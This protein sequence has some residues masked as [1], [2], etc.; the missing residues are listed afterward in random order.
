MSE[1]TNTSITKIIVR[2]GTNDD[3]TKTTLDV[4]EPGWST[5]T[6]Q[7]FIGDGSSK[8]GI[9]IGPNGD[10]TGSIW[11][12]GES[13]KINYSAGNV[14]INT[15]DPS[16]DLTVVG[17]IQA[18]NNIY[19]TTGNFMSAGVDIHT[20]FGGTAQAGIW[21]QHSNTAVYDKQTNNVA[22]RIDNGALMI[23]GHSGDNQGGRIQLVSKNG[24]AK[25]IIHIDNFTS[26]FRI[27]QNKKSWMNI[28]KGKTT[29][30]PNISADSFLNT[31][32]QAI[33]TVGGHNDVL[34]SAQYNAVN[35][36]QL[37]HN[38][39]GHKDT[40]RFMGRRAAAG[41]DWRTSYHQIVR[42]V[43]ITPMG[44]I[45]FGGNELGSTNN[46]LLEFGKS[47]TTY[48]EI[49]AD[50]TTILTPDATKPALKI[51]TGAGEGKVLTSDA[52]GNAT[53]GAGGAGGSGTTVYKL[54]EF[55]KGEGNSMG[56]NQALYVLDSDKNIRCIGVDS[57]SRNGGIHSHG[58]HMSY[59][60]LPSTAG[61]HDKPYGDITQ[62]VS[63]CHNL[64]V[65]TSSGTVFASGFNYRGKLGL[66]GG[67]T[68]EH[69]TLSR[70]SVTN[71]RKIIV[72]GGGI[73]WDH[74]A[75]PGW[76]TTYYLKTND[77]LWA[78]GQDNEGMFF[79]IGY[80]G[81]M[82]NGH[83]VFGPTKV[84]DNVKDALMFGSC[85]PGI[86]ENRWHG[87]GFALKNDGTVWTVGTP[88][89]GQLGHGNTNT[90]EGY[91]NYWKQ[92]GA[93]GTTNLLAGKNVVKIKGTGYYGNTTLYALTD[94]GKLYGWGRGD[95][96]QL[97]Q[98]NY[99]QS[100][101]EPVLVYS[102]VEDFWISGGVYGSL[103][104]KGTNKKMYACGYNGRGQLGTGEI[105]TKR[106][107][108][109]T[110]PSLTN[111]T[112]E[113]GMIYT[114]SLGSYGHAVALSDPAGPYPG[115]AWAC[116]Y[117]GDGQ[118]GFGGKASAGRAKWSRI[119]FNKKII[120]VRVWY[121]YGEGGGNTVVVSEDG[122]LYATGYG[123]YDIFSWNSSN[124]R[125][126]SKISL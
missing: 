119:P 97:A 20:L 69:N 84:L 13:N 9:L 109:T 71:V 4:G 113:I 122:E 61:G 100:N 26:Y 52:S 31:A 99:N 11:A 45:R 41:T 82:V 33:L 102:N 2:H 23:T 24:A 40:L 17:D 111:L 77:E 90:G 59:V 8:G 94:D 34:K 108:L 80:T 83:K 53:W 104:I 22:V 96:G 101:W 78:V 70:V 29:L 95:Y 18:S 58:P 81:N 55:Q 126:L 48:M 75:G 88:G 32:E 79:G 49:Q 25:N 107:S 1:S 66:V 118:C 120:D 36:L 57:Y 51:P 65:L 16:K 121:G 115:R 37:H 93:H 30:S 76:D 73:G 112:E 87:N 91:R 43:D 38:A 5:D 60:R 68:K 98:G 62:V 44:F 35:S 27:N 89:Y 124:R 14:G 15:V 125:Y 116:G 117:D 3:R 39:G 86:R 92:V 50:G 67:T 56:Q 123:I 46:E 54:E 105:Y 10:S 85:S 47:E 106:N 110:I 21:S 42:Q 114:G 28:R 7:F 6:K 72:A 12:T 64:W 19:T 63:A 74:G 103:Y